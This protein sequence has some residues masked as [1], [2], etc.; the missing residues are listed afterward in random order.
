M[1]GQTAKPE[2]CC[3]M[4]ID[5]LLKASLALLEY[6]CSLGTRSCYNLCYQSC[7]AS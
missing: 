5:L 1:A 4:F 2:V 3:L 7:D 6:N